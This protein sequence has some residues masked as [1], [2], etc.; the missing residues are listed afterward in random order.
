MTLGI[1]AAPS[2][3]FFIQVYFGKNMM[4]PQAQ[5]INT[6]TV[7]HVTTTTILRLTILSI[8][9]YKPQCHA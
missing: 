5:F 8:F 7:T 6:L 3:L 2:R 9:S 4:K 1:I